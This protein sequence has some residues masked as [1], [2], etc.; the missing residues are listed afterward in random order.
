MKGIII[1][2]GIGGLAAAIAIRQKGISV[3]VVEAAPEIKAVGA[4]IIMAS[5]AMQILQRLGIA[6]KV[7]DNGYRLTSGQ[8]ADQKWRS[9]Q[10][11]DGEYAISKYGVGSYAIHRAALRQILFDELPKE[12]IRLNYAVESVSQEDTKVFV[13]FANGIQEE[14]DFLIGADG[15][16][17]VVRQSLFGKT[18]YRYSGQTCWRATV[19]T[20]I[21]KKLE[22]SAYELWGSKPGLRWGM[23]PLS[24]G[25]IYFFATVCSPA[26][27]KDDTHTLKSNLAQQFS[28]F[29]DEITNLLEKTESTNI[30]RTDIYDFV[31][32]KKWHQGRIVLIGDAAHA[33]TPNLGQ[34]GCQALEDAYVIAKTLSENADLE[35]AFNLFQSTRYA[36]AKYV[37]DTS[38]LFGKLTNLSAP[39]IQMRN[40][41]IRLMPASAAKKS[42]DKLFQLNY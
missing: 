10:R 12:I 20:T 31:P 13:K 33:T 9:I 30:V 6:D 26:G 36:K 39:W 35:K 14:A 23:V 34:G 37:V 4:G 42:A 15:I 8:I 7:K 21:P 22:M 32:I 40:A 19:N 11:I 17:S 38:W 24:L 41:A 16:K 3:T 5:N 25:Q 29:G 28:E 1:G 27:G 2:A 18:N